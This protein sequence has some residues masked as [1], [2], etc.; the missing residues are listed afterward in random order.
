MRYVSVGLYLGP[1]KHLYGVPTRY[2]LSLGASELTS[3]TCLHV[4][5][6]TFFFLPLY[7]GGAW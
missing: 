4:F 5:P 7:K 6:Y 2:L 3:F 1:A